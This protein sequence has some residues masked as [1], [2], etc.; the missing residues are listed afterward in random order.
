MQEAS[1]AIEELMERRRTPE[2]RAE[3]ER[4][5]HAHEDQGT[6]EALA[7]RLLPTFRHGPN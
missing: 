1:E 5:E 6:D 4:S 7:H 2:A 3:R